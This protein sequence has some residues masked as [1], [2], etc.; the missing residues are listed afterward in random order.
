MKT[1]V[2]PQLHASFSFL[3]KVVD[4]PAF[5]NDR[6]LWSRQCRKLCPL[7][8]HSCSTSGR[9]SM[10]LLC[11]RA[12]STGAGRCPCCAGRAGF[13][14]AVVEETVLPQLQIV[15][16]IRT[17]SW[18]KS[19]P[20]PFV[21]N[22]RCCWGRCRA[23][24]WGSLSAVSAHRQGLHYGGGEGAFG[25]R[26]AI[27]RPPSIRTLRPRWRGRRESDFQAFCHLNSVHACDAISSEI[28]HLH[29]VRTTTTT[30][31]STRLHNFFLVNCL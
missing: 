9:W 5:V 30:Q 14:G 18:T 20:R 21:C 22:D 13:S 1:A 29:H 31:G 27:F 3:D 12:R 15:E 25:G 23:E 24:N 28:R 8:F 11:C 26:D 19:L 6:C 7:R 16:K 2:I 17:C 4:M 10:S